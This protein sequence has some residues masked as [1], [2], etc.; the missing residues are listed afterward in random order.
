MSRGIKAL[1]VIGL[2]VLGVGMAGVGFT[3]PITPTINNFMFICGSVL[4]IGAGIY[5]FIKMVT[6]K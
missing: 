4:Y 2:V 1:F 6:M 5:G 3:V